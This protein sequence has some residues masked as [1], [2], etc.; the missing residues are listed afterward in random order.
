MNYIDQIFHRA[1]LQ[2]LASFL[3]CGVE[4]N[5][6]SQKSYQERLDETGAAL[7]HATEVYFPDRKEREDF[8]RLILDSWGAYES[9]YL[10]I[11]LL[12][13]TKLSR[14]AIDCVKEA[15]ER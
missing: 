9:V 15:R 6:I 2:Q 8:E 4:S 3:L 10:E 5:V 7:M 11:G 14:Q 13:G 12:T 1:D